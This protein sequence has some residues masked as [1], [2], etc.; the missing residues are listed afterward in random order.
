M[1]DPQAQPSPGASAALNSPAA[2]GDFMKAL[3]QQDEK[4]QAIVGQE[5]KE[6][7]PAMDQA[8]MALNQPRPQAPQLQHLLCSFQ[9]R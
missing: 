6:M 8:N 7:A 1:P 5:Q 2:G 9:G 3:T 4:T